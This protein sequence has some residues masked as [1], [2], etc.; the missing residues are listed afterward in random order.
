[1]KDEIND[2][3]ADSCKILKRWTNYFF[4]LLK[5]HTICVI[6]QIKIHT[7]EPLVL[8]P[9]PFEFEIAIAQLKENNSPGSDQ[10]LAE[11]IHAG[12]ETL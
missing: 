11:M 7:A 6:I 8:D 9:N 3:L 5:V 2:L 12:D 1:M 4:E 10:I